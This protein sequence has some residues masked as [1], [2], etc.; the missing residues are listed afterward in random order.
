MAQTPQGAPSPAT[1]ESPKCP[2][3]GGPMRSNADKIAAGKNVPLWTCQGSKYDAATKS[4]M[5]CAGVI[6]PPKDAGG[7][8]LAVQGPNMAALQNLDPGLADFAGKLKL[9]LPN[10]N[11][12]SD[13]EALAGAQYAKTT[14]LDPFRGEFYV[15]PSIG[16][17]PGYKGALA[18]D[19][20]QG[21]APDYRY[22]PLTEDE[23]EWHDIQS[24]DK[25]CICY[26]TDPAE[27]VVA[28]REGRPPRVWEGVGIVRKSDQYISYEWKTAQSGSKYKAKLPEA[29]W[30]GRADPPQGRSWGW[31]AQKTALK[32]CNNHMGIP[33]EMD[34]AQIIASAQAAGISVEV[35][36]GAWID[37]EQAGALVAE[38]VQAHVRQIEPP[39]V[40]AR[41]ERNYMLE[42]FADDE[43]TPEEPVF[44]EPDLHPMWA[45]LN[46]TVEAHSGAPTERQITW[47]KDV[48]KLLAPDAANAIVLQWAFGAD[49]EHLTRGMCEGI[50]YWSHV[51][52]GTDN[53]LVVPPEKIA[54]W[55][56]A[57]A[58]L[59][60]AAQTNAEVEAQP[61]L[62]A[63]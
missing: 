34:A 45:A 38:A 37:S 7:T 47:T 24:G 28:R 63:E 41:D 55:Q 27:E 48:L 53:V 14:G 11:K 6:W 50:V 9:L 51:A 59:R 21:R 58:V 57:A 3:C 42:G 35:P 23:K 20:M 26:A 36:E 2:K 62:L 39:A 31:V 15:V 56:N 33:V 61:S 54:E 30:K 10:G 5:G 46:E 8:A 44:A 43:P 4:E 52:K 29:E 18:R 22:R 17:V 32:D 13:A 60:A 12:L 1:Q 25:A 16:V 40:I 49:A 19:G